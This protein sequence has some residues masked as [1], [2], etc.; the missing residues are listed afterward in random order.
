MR[1]R[2]LIDSHGAMLP[3]AVVVLGVIIS[4]VGLALDTTRMLSS[5]RDAQRAAD[6]ASLSGARS[7]GICQAPALDPEIRKQAWRDTKK[8]ILAAISLNGIYNL[9][10][11]AKSKLRTAT[12]KFQD[13]TSPA[14]PGDEPSYNRAAGIGGNL[15]VT[16]SRGI[17]CYD[18]DPV[19]GGFI[20][21]WYSLE[22]VIGVGEPPG[23]C[24][25]NSARVRMEIDSVSATFL[26]LVGISSI[27]KIRV[28]SV[29]YLKQAKICGT[30]LCANLG[31]PDGDPSD[32]ATPRDALGYTFFRFG[33][34]VSGVFVEDNSCP[35]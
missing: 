6:A 5:I 1:R 35:T 24:Y 27:P 31:I 34:Y 17:H 15:K 25:A 4:L 9:D 10:S 8:A 19:T 30:P 14:T 33:S 7:L 20:R 2:Q 13:T 11:S 18:Q 29:A 23:Y 16:A 32:P 26:R 21:R 12:F 22:K 28:E 3:F